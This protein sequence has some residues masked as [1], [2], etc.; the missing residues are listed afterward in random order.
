M[1]VHAL[2]YRIYNYNHFIILLVQLTLLARSTNNLIKYTHAA[3]VTRILESAA[4]RCSLSAAEFRNRHSVVL[5]TDRHGKDAKMCVLLLTTAIYIICYA[6]A[7]SAV[8]L[9]FVCVP[10]FLGKVGLYLS[11]R[12][13]VFETNVI[14]GKTIA[15]RKDVCALHSDNALSY[16]YATG[17]IRKSA[18]SS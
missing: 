10:L 2:I 1:R 13:G 4:V 7:A 5:F 14:A 12:N 15:F 16:V 17:R 18:L 9:Y 3:L 11:H 6:F 8:I